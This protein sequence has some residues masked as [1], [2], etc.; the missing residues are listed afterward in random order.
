MVGSNYDNLIVKQ[1]RKHSSE[2]KVVYLVVPEGGQTRKHCF[3]AMFPEGGQIRKHCFLA[4]FFEGGQTRK[5][6]FLAMFPE[7][8]QTWKRCFRIK[9]Q[10]TTVSLAISFSF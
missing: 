4:I 5:H 1:S 2:N 3:L 6:Y 7:G 8:G 10:M 9:Y